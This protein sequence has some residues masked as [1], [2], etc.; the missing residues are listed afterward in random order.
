MNELKAK[1]VN[2][3]NEQNL[4]IVS[5]DYQGSKLYMMS[6]GLKDIDLEKEVILGIN[7]SSFII[8]KDL[9]GDISLL[10]KLNCE[11]VELKKGKLLSSLSLKINEDLLTS[12]IATKSV[13]KL[14]LKENDILQVF[15]KASDISIKK[16]I[17]K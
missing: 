12:I 13:E 7:A 4:N 1:V 11:L 15:I 10:N 8:G 17:D 16:V 14:N 6:L 5:F 3:Q 9:K 2:I